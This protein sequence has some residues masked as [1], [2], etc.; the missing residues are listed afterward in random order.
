[1]L[2]EQDLEARLEFGSGDEA[3]VFSSATIDGQGVRAGQPVRRFA[4]VSLVF[5]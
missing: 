5:L 2:A 3:G 4:I 1:L